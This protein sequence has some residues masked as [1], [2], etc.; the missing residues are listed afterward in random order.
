MA[1]DQ[2][3]DPFEVDDSN[4]IGDYT[5]VVKAS[6]FEVDEDYDPETLLLRWDLEITG[7]DMPFETRKLSF[8][9]GKKHSTEDG[10]LTA[11]H[12]SRKPIGFHPDSRMGM[13]C[14]RAF[15]NPDSGKR[16]PTVAGEKD[17]EEVEPFGLREYFTTLGKDPL[18]ADAWVGIEF[19]I[20][21]ETK[22]YGGEIGE[23]P[24]ELPS[25]VIAIPEAGKP[26]AATKKKAAAKKK[27][28]GRKRA[29]T[30]KEEAA[31]VDWGLIKEKTLDAGEDVDD[32]GE[33]VAAGLKI[34]NDEGI[35][36]EVES[37]GFE[38][39]SEWLEDEDEGGW[40]EYGDP[41]DE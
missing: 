36:T 30:K 14:H 4:A 31:P 39:F 9:C 40:S 3:Y 8:T 34:V 19:A 16:P 37:E 22:D 17:G 10:G 29:A 7:G 20:G 38:A 11:V 6:V 1:E 23:K 35:D 24:V 26:K 33:F 2:E 18:T 21:Q 15:Y 12:E 5:A 13:L 27:A 25:A 28:G 41:D 32:H